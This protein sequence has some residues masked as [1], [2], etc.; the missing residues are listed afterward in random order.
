MNAEPTPAARRGF[1][2]RCPRD[3][4]A[5]RAEVSR[6]CCPACRNAYPVVA[7]VPVLIADEN[8]VFAIADY[9]E[10]PGYAGPS[11]GRAADGARGWRR[12]YRRLARALAFEL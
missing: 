10:G 2:L 3:G 7:G 8:S 1:R 12:R 11:Y 9:L 4:A 6:L 5:L